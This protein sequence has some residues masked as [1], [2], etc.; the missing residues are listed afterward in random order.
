[1]KKKHKR[2]KVDSI[3]MLRKIPEAGPHRILKIVPG[4]TKHDICLP[5]QAIVEKMYKAGSIEQNIY[6]AILDELRLASDHEAA[7]ALLA[8][9]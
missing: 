4:V 8:G 5:R 3:V 2:F 7:M 9:L 1:M 6:S